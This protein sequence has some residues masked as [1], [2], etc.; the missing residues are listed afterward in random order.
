MRYLWIEGKNVFSK[1]V[2]TEGVDWSDEYAPEVQAMRFS[3]PIEDIA[4]GCKCKPADNPCEF[5]AQKSSDCV[6]INFVTTQ[7]NSPS[8]STIH[9][10]KSL[11]RSS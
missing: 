9:A 7:L 4:K 1:F 11:T 6:N 8:T 2:S 5:Q 10:T 3:L